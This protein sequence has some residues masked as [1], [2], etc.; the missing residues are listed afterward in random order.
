MPYLSHKPSANLRDKV[1]AES[2][3]RP[4]ASS[5][6]LGFVSLSAVLEHLEVEH[7]SPTAKDAGLTGDALKSYNDLDMTGAIRQHIDIDSLSRYILKNVPEIKLPIDIE[8]FGFGQSNPTYKLNAAD[9]RSFVLRKKPPGQLLSKTAHQVEREYRIIHAL[10]N[11]DVPV[12]KTYCFCDEPNVIQTPFY[13]MEYLDGRIFEDAS[14]PN[15]SEVD[16]REMWHDA[17]YTLGKL[18]RLTP[19]ALTLSD[20]GKPSG[21]Y[22]RQIRTLSTISESQARVA[23]VV[24]NTEVG[25]IPYFEN[26]VAFFRQPE[27]QPRD[28]TCLIHGDYKIDNLVFHKTDPRVIGILDWEMSTLGHPLS[29]LSNLLSPFVLALHGTPSALEGRI[30]PAFSPSASP[31]GLPSRTQCIEWYTEMADW[32]PGHD[33]EWGD[34]FGLFRNSVIMQGI[35]ARYALRQASSA[36]AKEYAVQMGPFG[37]LAWGLVARQKSK[38]QPK[39]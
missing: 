9:G 5:C 8:Q 33:I 13:I 39:L 25:R 3:E 24:T 35:A 10:E 38:K 18:H 31:P 23:D 17:I 20:F 27:T 34:S 6:E 7:C 28:R 37:K 32:N 11:T 15:V 16:R 30:N 14:L 21:F 1:L 4:R 29:D 26:M 2:H 12:P 19:G 22:S 36:Q